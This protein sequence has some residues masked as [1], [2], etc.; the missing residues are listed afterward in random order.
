VLALHS[1]VVSAAPRY[2]SRGPGRVG[3]RRC[4]HGPQDEGIPVLVYISS[5]DARV[6]DRVSHNPSRDSLEEGRRALEM[7]VGALRQLRLIRRRNGRPSIAF[8][9]SSG[10]TAREI[11]C[12]HT[13]KN[14]LGAGD[15][16]DSAPGARLRPSGKG[17]KMPVFR[18]FLVESACRVSY[19]EWTAGTK[20]GLP[21][22]A[23]NRGNRDI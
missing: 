20:F 14:Y 13:Q 19:T 3:G 21:Y 6:V 22:C 9:L 11:C 8:P 7:A 10:A 15:R 4:D 12:N 23:S 17:Q 1:G 5:S 18:A 2:E 16:S